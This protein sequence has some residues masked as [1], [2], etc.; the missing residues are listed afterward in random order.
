MRILVVDDHDETR[1]LI[2]RHFARAAHSVQTASSCAEAARALEGVAFDIVLLDVMLPDGSGIEF[3]ARL[4]EQ[5]CAVPVLLLTARSDV[6]DR[7]QGLDAGADDYLVKPFAL[8]ELIARVRALARRGPMLRDR[9]LFFGSVQVDLERRCVSVGGRNLPLTAKEIA[10][11]ELLATR[12]GVVTREALMESV[13]GDVSEA[14]RASLDVFIGRI[15]RKLDGHG[16]V[17]RT[18]RGLG[19]ALES[20]E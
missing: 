6:R 8:A 7:V 13:W 14:S 18:I 11:V 12:R 3:C 16:A 9:T 2:T 20:G 19:Y 17:L 10:I 15:R 1:D 5:G 4:R